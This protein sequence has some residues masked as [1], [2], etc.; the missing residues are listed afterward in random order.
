VLVAAF[1]GYGFSR[2]QFRGKNAL[3]QS[4]LLIR[5][6][7]TALIVIPLYILI[8]RLRLNN[9]LFALVLANTSFALPLS[10]FMLKG[11]FDTVPFEIE[12]AAIMDGCNRFQILF[13]IILP[14]TAPG[15][16]ATFLYGFI[17]G[18]SEFLFAKTFV[19]DGSLFTGAVGMYTFIGE[20]V[21]HWSEMM[22][23][24]FLY[25]L[26]VSILFL[27]LQKYL[28]TGLAAGAVKK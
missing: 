26:P 19:S 28:V 2:Y 9:T 23:A 27:F 11:Y 6:I 22:A 5:M 8:I 20:H 7:P 14:I 3:Q 15:I 12:E 21:A 1:G 10:L 4:F 13:K 17:M 16:A 24:A 25:S 18:W